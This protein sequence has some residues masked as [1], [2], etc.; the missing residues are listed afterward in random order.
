MEVCPKQCQ[1]MQNLI[2]LGGIEMKLKTLIVGMIIISLSLTGCGNS[3]DTSSKDTLEKQTTSVETASNDKKETK[4]TEDTVEV[5]E[6]DSE[7]VEGKT[8][9]SDTSDIS[10]EVNSDVSESMDIE[11]GRISDNDV[12]E[13]Y[14]SSAS[15]DEDIESLGAE[16]SINA[17][18]SDVDA[19]GEDGEYVNPFDNIP[20]DYDWGFDLDFKMWEDSTIETSIIDEPMEIASNDD[21]RVA[22][23]KMGRNEFG[24]LAIIECENKTDR[25]IEL[26]T[27]QGCGDRCEI[28]IL[29]DGEE[30]GPYETGTYKFLISDDE[31]EYRGIQAI[32]DLEWHLRVHDV[33][34]Y[35]DILEDGVVELQLSDE[36]LN[37]FSDYEVDVYVDRGVRFVI[38]PG[39]DSDGNS[40]FD[41]LLE[42]NTDG[43]IFFSLE[44]IT[45]DGEE[46]AIG[47]NGSGATYADLLS[48]IT[49]S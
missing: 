30:L 28:T 29:K 14:V 44:K 40:G 26:Q 46:I 5:V 33:N 6:G 15:G 9:V 8:E 25:E 4:S 7:V 23:M 36:A 24:T 41:A 27:A 19:T 39:I 16:D 12:G 20:D 3:N 34:T 10:E 1:Q 31:L 18:N 35:E 32:K 22:L 48:Y 45:V 37:N 13:S 42:N 49:A 21:T 17:N 47:T 38:N 43:D 11:D 2:N